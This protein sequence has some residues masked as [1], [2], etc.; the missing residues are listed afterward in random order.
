M[1]GKWEYVDYDVLFDLHERS[2]PPKY[3]LT[4]GLLTSHLERSPF[5][6]LASSHWLVFNRALI[7]AL[8][9]KRPAPFQTPSQAHLSFLC[10]QHFDAVFEI[11]P[12]VLDGLK[13]QGFKK[14]IFGQDSRHFFPGAPE[15]WTEI[16]KILQELGFEPLN[17]QVDLE[18]DLASYQPPAGAL[19]PLGEEFIVRPCE[20]GDLA[21]V[22]RF[23]DAEFPGRWKSDTFEKWDLDSPACVLGLFCG[24]ECCGFALTQ[25][26]GTPLPIGGAVWGES[27][28]ANWGSLG[29]IGVAKDLRGRGLGDALLAASLMDLQRRGAQRTIIDWTTLVNYYGKHGFEVTRRYKAMAL[30]LT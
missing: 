19:D 18:R 23:F 16:G 6:D 20:P 7:G 22:T 5:L 2:S 1:L 30:P 8:A 11:M 9:I 27:L 14:L 29:P 26:D 17:D 3:R 12:N 24:S 13:S 10:F 15:D 28:G 21:S 25:H 4:R